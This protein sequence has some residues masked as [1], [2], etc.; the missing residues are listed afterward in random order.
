MSFDRFNLYS[1]LKQVSPLNK[2]VRLLQVNRISKKWHFI[3]LSDMF[4]WKHLE[5]EMRRR[6]WRFIWWQRQDRCQCTIYNIRDRFP[7]REESKTYSMPEF[8]LYNRKS[9]SMLRSKLYKLS[10]C[11][12]DWWS[13]YCVRMVCFYSFKNITYNLI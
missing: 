1:K 2:L 4:P 8:L 13:S 3:N 9:S 7:C 12:C 6:I 10:L 11:S 5:T